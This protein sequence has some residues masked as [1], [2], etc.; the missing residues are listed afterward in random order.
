MKVRITGTV[1]I[2]W[3]PSV[4]VDGSYNVIES[5]GGINVSCE[6]PDDASYDEVLNHVIDLFESGREWGLTCS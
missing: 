3:Y 4:P 6:V 1:T 5:D 2:S